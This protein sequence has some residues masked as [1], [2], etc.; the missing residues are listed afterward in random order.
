MIES[1]VSCRQEDEE[2]WFHTSGAACLPLP[3]GTQEL[4]SGWE[5]TLLFAS[6]FLLGCLCFHYTPTCTTTSP[7]SLHYSWCQP[8]SITH[9]LTHTLIVN[10]S[11]SHL[12]LL[13]THVK[14]LQR[15]VCVWLY[16]ISHLHNFE[17]HF[18]TEVEYLIHSYAF[19][20][21]IGYNDDGRILFY[22]GDFKKSVNGKWYWYTDIYGSCHHGNKR[23]QPDLVNYICGKF[24][25]F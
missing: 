6:F 14:A 7:S 21:M 16:L 18:I 25:Y 12:S 8:H 11:V 15:C 22:E 10:Y 9:S 23:S 3:E 5:K 19:F 17:F 2:V 24:R 13:W 1:Q 4:N 20:C